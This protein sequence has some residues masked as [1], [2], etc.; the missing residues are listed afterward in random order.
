MMNLESN[1]AAIC[2]ELKVDAKALEPL[3]AAFQKA[4]DQRRELM[5]EGRQGGLDR[6]AMR[7]KMGPVQE[8]LTKAMQ[9]YLTKEQLGRLEEL[10]AQRRSSWQRG[11]GGGGGWGDGAVNRPRYRP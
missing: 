10:H 1:W 4:W 6:V 8:G 5:E 9:Q 3:R 11:G 2:F 7:E